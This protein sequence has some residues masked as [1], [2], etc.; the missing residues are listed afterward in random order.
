MIVD[1]HEPEKQELQL[2]DPLADHVPALQ[3]LLHVDCDEAPTTVDHVP[4]LHKLQVN[5][6]GIDDHVPA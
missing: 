2:E 1:D 6:I 4:A 5:A 3:M